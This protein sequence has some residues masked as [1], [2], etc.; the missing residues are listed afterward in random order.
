MNPPHHWI[1][2]QQIRSFSTRS[3]PAE[4]YHHCAERVNHHT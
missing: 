3:P 1:L 2:L 4:F